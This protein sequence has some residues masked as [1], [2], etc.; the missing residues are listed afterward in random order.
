M[1]GTSVFPPEVLGDVPRITVIGRDRMRI[2]QHHGLSLWQED[3]V[4]FRVAGGEVVLLGHDLQ[5]TAYTGQEATVT[6]RL[7]GMTFRAAGTRRAEGR[8]AAP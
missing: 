1:I 8:K 4:A 5:L 7:T 6:G 2:E 3:E